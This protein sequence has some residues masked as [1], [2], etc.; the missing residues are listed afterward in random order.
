M[1]DD[2]R[3]LVAIMASALVRLYEKSQG[4]AA[5]SKLERCVALGM[6]VTIAV[7]EWL[8]KRMGTVCMYVWVSVVGWGGW[9]HL[10]LIRA[11]V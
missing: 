6:A 10:C 3:D 9:M 11:R 7:T 4:V 1:G 2:A 8:H 5:L